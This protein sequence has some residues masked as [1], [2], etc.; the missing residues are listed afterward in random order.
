MFSIYWSVVREISFWK[1]IDLDFI[2]VEGEKLYKTLNFQ[3]YLNVDQLP[4]QVQIFRYTVNLEILEEN[5]HDG[6]SIYGDSFLTDVFNISNA[7]NSSGCIL[8]LCSYA[9][10]MF[11]HVNGTGNV[12]YFLFD[13]YCRNS[14]GITDGEIRFSIL[15]KCESLFQIERYIEEA[16]QIS[17][18]MYPPYIQI[19]FIS[20]IL[21]VD[22]LV[23]IIQFCQKS[24]FRQI[25]RQQRQIPKKNIN[26][27]KKRKIP[28]WQKCVHVFKVYKDTKKLRI[29]IGYLKG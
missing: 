20:V 9:V 22:E 8:F 10:A 28:E 4:R 11:K 18:K 27:N 7:N 1:T 13:S 16:Y 26:N 5:L 17:G 15:M 24:N 25:K 19:Q 2:L 6:I 14:R 12:S 21:S 23:I 3:S 29:L